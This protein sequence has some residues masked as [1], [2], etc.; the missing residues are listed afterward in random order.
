MADSIWRVQTHINLI[1]RRDEVHGHRL[2]GSALPARTGTLP[3][4]TSL[5]PRVIARVNSKEQATRET[6][7][8]S[9][10][11]SVR[12]LC[13]GSANCYLNGPAFG[14]TIHMNRALSSC[15][16]TTLAIWL[17]PSGI[18]DMQTTFPRLSKLI[19]ASPP[20]KFSRRR[21]DASVCNGHFTGLGLRS[22]TEESRF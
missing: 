10:H 19:A 13:P 9:D 7:S 1:W 17:L 16:D 20:G 3:H 11:M 8:I 22:S 12:M 5:S 4:G 15:R 2:D 18:S 6:A 21:Q 14:I